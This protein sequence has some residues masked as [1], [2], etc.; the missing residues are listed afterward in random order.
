MLDAMAID[1]FWKNVAPAWRAVDGPLEAEILETASNA[2][3]EI[4]PQLT[5]EGAKIPGGSEVIFG[6]RGVLRHFKLA[7]EMAAKAPAMPGIKIRAL[8]DPRPLPDCVSKDGVELP[9][10]TTR[11]HAVPVLSRYG[12]LLLT[13]EVKINDY[14]A[15]RNLAKTVVMDL[16]GEER[17]GLFVTDVQVMDHADWETGA[18][19]VESLPLADLARIIPHPAG[20][21]AAAPV[22]E[23]VQDNNR[24]DG[25]RAV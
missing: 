5:L 2:L 7:R 12:V 21:T 20:H 23:V 11:F 13:R 19:G 25:T 4:A 3:S 24:R 17:Y 9:L 14:V 6:A 18:G 22:V 1:G 8:R 16:I 15:F 10:A